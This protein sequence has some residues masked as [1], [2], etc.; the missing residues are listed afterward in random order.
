MTV[1]WPAYN[2]A[3]QP[4]D[5]IRELSQ[6]YESS[7]RNHELLV[8]S[9]ENAVVAFE[10]EECPSGWVE[11]APAFGRF[12]RG[13]DRGAD[14]VDPAGLREPG[15]LQ[16]DQYRSHSHSLSRYANH[17]PNRV[18]R[19]GYDRFNAPKVQQSETTNTAASGGPETRPANVALLFCRRE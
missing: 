13:I 12:I 14:P 1:P 19:A 18:G 7:L 2:S 16:D 15:S 17:S 11:Y 3:G 10:S 4:I 9:L 8:T 5:L 6:R